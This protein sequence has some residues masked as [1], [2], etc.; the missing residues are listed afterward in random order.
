M[1]GLQ[2]CWSLSY[3]VR[4]DFPGSAWNWDFCSRDP[5]SERLHCSCDVS[6]SGAGWLIAVAVAFFLFLSSLSLPAVSRMS[7]GGRGLGGL[8]RIC[9]C[10]DQDWKS[11]SLS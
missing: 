6:E 1:G 8:Y 10:G 4:G 7:G 5:G 9:V 3:R 2:K 11:R